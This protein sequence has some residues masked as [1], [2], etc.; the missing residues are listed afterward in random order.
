MV[1]SPLFPKMLKKAGYKT[2]MV[3]KWHLHGYPEG[4]DY[5]NILNDQGNYYNPQFIKK[6]DSALLDKNL[7]ES[8]SHWNQ[9]LPDTLVVNGYA[10]DLITEDALRFIKE[11]KN[12]NQPFLLM[13][14]HKAP[15]RNWMPALRHLNKYEK[16]KNFRFLILILPIIKVLPRLKSNFKRSTVICM[17]VTT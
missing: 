13:V 6:K 17:K 7:V 15:H 4:F 12:S 3:G 16:C 2:A 9:K 11:N 8:T 10:T 14:H 1:R 5:W